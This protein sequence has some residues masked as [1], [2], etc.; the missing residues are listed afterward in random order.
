MFPILQVWIQDNHSEWFM[1]PVAYLSCDGTLTP[2]WSAS[3]L[4]IV[5][6]VPHH[7]CLRMLVQL[8]V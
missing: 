5:G 8:H 6:H 2:W 1:A 3:M 7:V 4:V